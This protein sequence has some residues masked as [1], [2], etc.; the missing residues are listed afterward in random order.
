MA[1]GFYLTWT[2]RKNNA[3]DTTVGTITTIQE[4]AAVASNLRRLEGYTKV[5]VVAVEDEEVVLTVDAE[6]LHAE[7]LD[8][9]TAE[10]LLWR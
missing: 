7:H 9:E 1:T 10:E 5:D 2:D 8:P 6:G 4:A 3:A